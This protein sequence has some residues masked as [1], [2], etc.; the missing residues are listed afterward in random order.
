MPAELL[1]PGFRINRNNISADGGSTSGKCRADF[2][3]RRV[4]IGIMAADGGPTSARHQGKV[5][6]T[7]REQREDVEP[8]LCR[9]SP[10]ADMPGCLSV[11]R[12]QRRADV[13]PMS[14]GCRLHIDIRRH[15]HREADFAPTAG[16]HATDVGPTSG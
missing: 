8:T 11:P 5:S 12:C 1:R 9:R 7:S 10:V 6:Y 4:N 14:A 2:G 13:G 3:R 16:R 15:I